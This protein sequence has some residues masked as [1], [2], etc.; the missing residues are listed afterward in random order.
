MT[1]YSSIFIKI[2]IAIAVLL[3]T[4]FCYKTIAYP[5]LERS[6]FFW[7]EEEKYFYQKI[8][9]FQKSGKKEIMMKDLT[10]FEWENVCYVWPYGG[11]DREFK[12]IELNKKIPEDDNEGKF[13]VIFIKNG[14]GKVFRISRSIFTVAESCL[15]RS[16]SLLKIK[17][18]K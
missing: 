3:I 14:S 6:G 1:K 5:R 7:S 11:I 8:E 4:I 17:N 2:L 18:T 9:E 10:N 16:A 15:S 12:D 13:A